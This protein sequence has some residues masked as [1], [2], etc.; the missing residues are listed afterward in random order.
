VTLTMTPAWLFWAIGFANAPILFGLAAASLPIL[1]HLFNRRKFREVEWA[2]MRFLLAALKKNSRRI[3]IEHWLLLLIRMM[4]VGA[5]VLAMA[6]PYLETFGNVISGR[7]THRVL[8]LDGSL[9]MAYNSGGTSRFDQ[10]KVLAAQLVKDSHRGDAVSMI[11]MGSPPRVVIGEPSANLESVKK[12]IDEL[13]QTHGSVD[14]LATFEAI[15]RVLEASSIDQ[16]EVVFVTDLQATSWR[17][18]SSQ[19][20]EA[21]KK[22]LAKLEERQA[23]SVLIDIGRTGEENRGITAVSL[24]QPVVTVGSNVRILAAVKNFGKSKVEGLRVRLTVDGRLG[25]EESRDLPPGE[26]AVIYFAHQFT[27]PGDHVLEVTIDDDPLS[28]DNHRWMVV[29]VRE[30]LNILLVDGHFKAEPYQAETDY[31]VQALNPSEAPPGSS[32]TLKTE[33]I[34]ESQLARHELAA[35]DAVV[36]CNVAQFSQAEVT[37][38]E[39]FLKR[40]GGVII[41]GGDQV[42]PDNYNRLLFA[43]GKGILPASFGPTRGDAT[44]RESAFAF[45]PLGYRDPILSEFRG[46]SDAILAGLTQTHIYQYHRLQIPKGSDSRVAMAFVTGDPAIIEAPRYRGTVIQVA[47]T[48]DSGWTSW[49]V[50][51][52]YPPIMQQLVMQASAGP[53]A[54]RN[55]RVGQPFDQ[56]FPASA[57]T[58]GVTVVNP[59]GVT[60]ATKLQSAGG[61]S[62]LLFEN[63]DLSGRYQARVASPTPEEISFAANPDPLESDLAKLEKPELAEVAPGWNVLYLTNWRELTENAESVGRR[64]EFHRPFL[65]ALLVLLLLESFLAWRF[66]HHGT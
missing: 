31:L 40:G 25:P 29:P 34:S 9:S 18:R 19:G 2:A 8:V 15:D 32:T 36:L 4:V 63:T 22:I 51:N 35:Y 59:K 54:E 58:S 61:V 10:A 37:A 41:F 11:L 46:Q 62:Q 3:R 56:S 42:V 52:S 39:D 7:R 66:G 64:G 20:P 48:A 6:R 53:I 13:S 55:I 47:T 50:H 44:R 17:Q 49:P 1:I 5:L 45:D 43:D 30:S 24:E 33:V 38:L 16:K 27:D 21:W 12:E 26:E 28:T 57:G 65:Y 60:T 14:L 23:R